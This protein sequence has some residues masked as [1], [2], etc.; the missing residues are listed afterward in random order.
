[1]LKCFFV[2]SLQNVLILNAL[3]NRS[4]LY[5]RWKNGTEKLYYQYIL[6]RWVHLSLQKSIN[7]PKLISL[8]FSLQSF[9]EFVVSSQYSFENINSCLFVC[10][11]DCL[12]WIT[13]ICWQE[14]NTVNCC[15]GSQFVKG[16]FTS[17]SNYDLFYVNC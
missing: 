9:R 5:C 13:W 4:I 6:T 2:M 15:Y 12:K 10:L 17:R 16:Y 1:M 14:T 7:S 8:H 11:C 3:T